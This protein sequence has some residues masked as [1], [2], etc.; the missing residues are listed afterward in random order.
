MLTYKKKKEE[1]TRLRARFKG[2]ND[3]KKKKKRF[4]HIPQS[5]KILSLILTVPLSQIFSQSN[6]DD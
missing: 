4:E 5:K 2:R 3:K 6:K 1:E